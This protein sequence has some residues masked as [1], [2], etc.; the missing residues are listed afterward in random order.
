MAKKD[1]WS[2]AQKAFGKK[3][4]STMEK[5]PFGKEPA[6]PGRPGRPFFYGTKSFL[7][8]TQEPAARSPGSS[9]STSGQST[10]TVEFQMLPRV[11]HCSQPC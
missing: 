11:R 4:F 7:P 9:S 6:A 5:E 2:G 10:L 3:S 8:M 1:W